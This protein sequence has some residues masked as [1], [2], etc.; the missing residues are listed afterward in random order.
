[1]AAPSSSSGGALGGLTRKVGPL[2]AWAWAALLLVG[3][4]IYQRRKSSA[5]SGGGQPSSSAANSTGNVANP[6]PGFDAAANT[7]TGASGYGTQP[8][9]IINNYYGT[10]AAGQATGGGT[11]SGGPAGTLGGGGSTKPGALSPAPVPQTAISPGRTPP[12]V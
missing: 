9:T 7:G 10:A 8:G 1:M 3:F 12:P 4:Y 5:A 6:V 2:P 11:S